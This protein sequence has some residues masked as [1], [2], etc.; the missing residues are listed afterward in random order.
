MSKHNQLLPISLTVTQQ[1][2]RQ[3][4]SRGEWLF[5]YTGSTQ[6]S[7]SSDKFRFLMVSHEVL[8]E[9]C[10][11]LAKH[12]TDRKEEAFVIVKMGDFSFIFN[13]KKTVRTN[14]KKSP[15]QIKRDGDCQR[16]L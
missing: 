7:F 13:N 16:D 12:L 2:Q 5:F 9:Q 4:F 1:H 10:L 11:D 14:R 6:N 8:L 3:Y 15:S